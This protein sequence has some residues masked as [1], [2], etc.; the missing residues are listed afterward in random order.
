MNFSDFNF[1]QSFNGGQEGKLYSSYD[2]S[3][4]IKVY[5]HSHI[6]IIGPPNSNWNYLSSFCLAPLLYHHGKIPYGF[7]SSLSYQPDFFGYNN[8]IDDCYYI[9]M[10]KLVGN[11]YD[12]SNHPLKKYFARLLITNTIMVGL[13]PDRCDTDQEIFITNHGAYWTD[14]DINGCIADF[15]NNKSE[16]DKLFEKL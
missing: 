6:P 5:K 13:I 9:I 16:L 7:T 3:Q 8:D 10:Q 1:S 12:S 14:L 15:D 11:A 4:C 2:G